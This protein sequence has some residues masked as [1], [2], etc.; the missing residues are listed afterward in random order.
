MTL[1]E[2]ERGRPVRIVEIP[3]ET[4]RAQC[5]RFGIGEGTVVD[6]AEVLPV[7]PVLVRLRNQEICFGR[8]LARSIRVE[9]ASAVT[10]PA[11]AGRA[12]RGRRWRGRKWRA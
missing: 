3:D 9:N 7:G 10:C 11:G 8:N 1:I 6:S 2:A 4:A 12:V 5:L